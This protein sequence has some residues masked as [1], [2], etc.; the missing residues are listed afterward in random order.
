M[1]R[2]LAPDVWVATHKLRFYGTPVVT[3]MTLLRLADGSL[4]VIGPVARSPELDREVAPL[5]PVR[6]VIA[7]NRYHH[8]YA[9]AWARHPDA[10]LYGAPGLAKK[11]RDLHLHGTLGS[12]APPEWAEQIDQELVGGLPILNEVVFFHRASRTL[13]V[14]DLFFN[15]PPAKSLFVRLVRMLED[16]DGKFTVPRLVRLMIRDRRAFARSVER[17]LSWDFD[18]LVMAHGTVLESGGHARA[19]EALGRVA[20]R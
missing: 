11:R 10:R 13:V 17:I 15:Y 16:C 20:A 6:F 1:L 5:G 3:R 18:R 8:L 14:T 19:A 2:S 4:F 7:P 12:I 9:G